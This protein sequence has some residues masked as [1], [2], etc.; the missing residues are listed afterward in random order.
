MHEQEL[1]KLRNYCAYQ[2]RA[3]SEVRSKCF[4]L[5]LKGEAIDQLITA[6]IEENFLNEERFACAFAGGRFRMKQWGRKKIVQELKMKQ[7]SPYCIKKALKEI[8]EDDYM[9]TLNK[10]AEKKYESLKGEQYLKRQ[11]KTMQFLLQ[12]GFEQELIGE[13]IK[14]IAKSSP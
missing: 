5:G 8:D 6:L 13:V 12:R 10:L 9:A 1:Q 7:V 14:Q 3:H 4:E 11:Y 2:E